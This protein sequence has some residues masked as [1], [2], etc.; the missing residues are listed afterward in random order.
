M[1]RQ[2][3][4]NKDYLL[5]KFP[6]KGGWTFAAIPEILPE[7]KNPFGWVRV[8]GTIDDV[9]IRNYHLMPMGNGQLFLPVKAEIRRQ[10]KKKAGDWIRVELF[11]DNDPVQIPDDL[12]ECLHDEPIALKKFNQLSDR[13]KINAI[14][15]I[16]GAKQTTTR[17]ARIVLLIA[18]LLKH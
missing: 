15:H 12:M 17:A 18:S 14:K 7:K 3:L 11:A 1:A 4:V 2:R 16:D 13:E 9:A 10:I 6:G 5:Q 8:K